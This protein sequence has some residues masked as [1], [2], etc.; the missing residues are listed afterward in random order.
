M[1]EKNPIP[2]HL[3][4]GSRREGLPSRGEKVLKPRCKLRLLHSYQ[5]RFI[6]GPRDVSPWREAGRRH[7]LGL[8]GPV[9]RPVWNDRVSQWSKRP[10]R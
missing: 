3:F 10:F 9:H 7:L 5:V 2:I 4:R 6:R 1:G 8:E